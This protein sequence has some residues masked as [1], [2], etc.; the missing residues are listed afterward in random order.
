MPMHDDE[1]IRAWVT[2]PGLIRTGQA[3][4][5]TPQEPQ[6]PDVPWWFVGLVALILWGPLLGG[7]VRPYRPR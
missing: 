4:D 5:E 1:A 2:E 3:P 7:A 6:G